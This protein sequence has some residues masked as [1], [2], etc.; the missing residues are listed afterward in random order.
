MLNM[1]RNWWVRHTAIKVS[2]RLQ[3]IYTWWIV[4]FPSGRLPL[5]ISNYSDALGKTW[6]ASRERDLDELSPHGFSSDCNRI[7]APTTIVDE[8]DNVLAWYLPDIISHDA[9][10]CLDLLSFSCY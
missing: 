10:V 7:E 5:R 9:H 6:G 3:P 8:E 4:Y 1:L 2:H